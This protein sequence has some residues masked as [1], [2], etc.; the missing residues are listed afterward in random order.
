M[1]RPDPLKEAVDD[2]SGDVDKYDT[3]GSALIAIVYPDKNQRLQAIKL[4]ESN[5][6]H[7]LD[8]LLRFSYDLWSEK[9]YRRI[10]GSQLRLLD[11][12]MPLGDAGD[13]YINLSRFYGAFARHPATDIWDMS[14]YLSYLTASKLIDFIEPPP[15]GQ[16]MRV[17]ITPSGVIFLTYVKSTYAHEWTLKPL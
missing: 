13:A 9:V 7:H 6:E 4:L 3:Q 11:Y 2:G 12:L 10:F 17:R 16:E 14:R 5:P 8:V 1:Q 15:G